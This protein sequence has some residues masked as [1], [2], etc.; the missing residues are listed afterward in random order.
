MTLAELFFSYTSAKLGSKAAVTSVD[1]QKDFSKHTRR[2]TFWLA[3][4]S[5]TNVSKKAD[6]IPLTPSEPISSL[7][8][9]THTA[10]RTGT[11][12]R[13]SRALSPA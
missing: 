10:V 7:S 9:S 1:R 4:K 13:S 11:P 3:H 8:A 12:S 5:P 2:G 6:C